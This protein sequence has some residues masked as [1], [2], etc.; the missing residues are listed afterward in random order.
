MG[1]LVDN[2]FKIRDGPNTATGGVVDEEQDERYLAELDQIADNI[3]PS[4]YKFMS[5][6]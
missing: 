5:T 1:D 6:T 4:D 3:K 2:Y